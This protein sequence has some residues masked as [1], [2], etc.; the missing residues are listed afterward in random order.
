MARYGGEEFGALL[1][2]TDTE[3]AM[4]GAER[5]REAVERID[6]L[7]RKITVSV[8]VA[9]FPHHGRTI[10]ELLKGADAALYV[11]K[12]A[13]RNQVRLADLPVG[14]ATAT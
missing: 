9:V 10:P 5:M 11:A 7:P 4:M 6:G 13:G 8:G 1:V 3:G 2:E 14:S 12:N